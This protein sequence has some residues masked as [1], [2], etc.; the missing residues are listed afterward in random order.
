ML[1]LIQQDSTGVKILALYTADQFPELN[2]ILLASPGV[3]SE[4]RWE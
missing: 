2:L 3:I 1:Y 4:H